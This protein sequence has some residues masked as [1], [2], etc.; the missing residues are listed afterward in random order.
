LSPLEQDVIAFFDASGP[1]ARLGRPYVPRPGQI[2]MA[3][4]IAQAIEAGEPLVVEAGTGIGKTYA[5]LAAALLSGRRTLVSTATQALQD[6]LFERDL[7]AVREALGLPLR[8]ALLKGRGSYL[9][10]HRLEQA[11][12]ALD[13]AGPGTLAVLARIETWAQHTRSGDLAEVAGLDAT[14]PLRPLVSSNRDNCLG[15]PCPRFRECHVHQARREALAADVVVV[16]HHLFFADMAVRQ[17]GVA[18]LLPSAGLVVFDEAHQ[19]QDTGAQFLGLQ[20]GS[21]QLLDLAR[22][23][24]RHGLQLARGLADWP[25]L[26]GALE[27]AV[28]D[29]G[30]AATLDRRQTTRRNWVGEA[31][32]GLA[33]EDW[34]A[35]LDGVVLALREL[36]LGLQTVDEIAPDL[37][38]LAERCGTL[39]AR[40]QDLR[41]P[42]AEWRAARWIELASGLRLMLSPLD[43]GPIFRSR[44]LE[45]EGARGSA[46]VFTSATLGTDDALSW[47]TTPMGLQDARV[48]RVPSPFDHAAQAALYLPADLP[49]PS[50][51]AHSE[52]VARHT[53]AW[54]KRLGGRTLVLTTTLRALRRV[55][56]LLTQW[57]AEPG[58]GPQ[59]EVLVQGQ[60]GRHELL[61]RFERAALPGVPGAVL[62]ASASFWEGVDLP[63]DALQ[64]VV[65]DKLPFPPPDD[66][67]VQARCHHIEQAGGAPFNRYFLPEAAV[68]LKQGAGRLIRSEHD[69]GVLVVCDV[70]LLGKGYGRRLLAGL[71]PMRRVPDAQAMEAELD[72][73]LTTA[74]T[75]ARPSA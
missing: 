20:L 24:L 51:P 5:Y 64:L 72:A 63:G 40:L 27:Q 8:T 74:S 65:I 57:S 26:A 30:L 68:A 11:R 53:W 54:A 69:R 42:P 19:L 58:T 37:R 34:R 2:A 33:P 56:E 67:L 43:I 15:S 49:T 29:L 44:V 41:E 4:A 6:Q 18:E 39:S 7:P 16:N 71:P 46:W 28:Q 47:F 3:Q 23:A 9:C 48:L 70:R 14:S 55:G 66:P 31:P 1:L 62:V 60:G 45:R 50:D 35:A 59:L 32:E 36:G 75:T 25:T 10:L 52:V 73:L 17:S 38:R 13:E 22:D 61:R 21:T 12:Q